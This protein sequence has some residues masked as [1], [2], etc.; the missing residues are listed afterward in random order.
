M[1]E[2]I[3]KEQLREEIKDY[4][5]LHGVG[6]FFTILSEI[7]SI[8]TVSLP[9]QTI[10]KEEIETEKTPK[11]D[12]PIVTKDKITAPLPASIY[13]KKHLPK[14]LEDQIKEQLYQA[15]ES[16]EPSSTKDTTPEENNELDTKTKV[17]T[18]N[19]PNN[20]PSAKTLIPGE[21]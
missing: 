5:N 15:L 18:N 20:F 16:R 14:V 19:I 4:V 8:K 10:P 3:T 11:E 6:S 9:E 21:K 1:E 7:F 2:K 17:L 13:D 12:T